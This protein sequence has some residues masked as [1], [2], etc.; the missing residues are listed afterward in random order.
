M[1]LWGAQSR[2]ALRRVLGAMSTGPLVRAADA[3]ETLPRRPLPR[4]PWARKLTRQQALSPSRW[5][6]Y[7]SDGTRTRTLHLMKWRSGDPKPHPGRDLELRL[8]LA[9]P[10]QRRS[11]R[12]VPGP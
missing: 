4:T 2:L 3:W 8:K 9:L 1:S 5:S 10:A 11:V 6:I 12:P 7:G